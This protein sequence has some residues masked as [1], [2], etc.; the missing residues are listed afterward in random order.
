MT[1]LVTGG[2]GQLG[3]ALRQVLPSATFAGSELDITDRTALAAHDW[4]GTTAIVNAAAWTA[5]DAAEQQ[6]RL[7]E[8][9]A[10]TLDAVRE[11]TDASAR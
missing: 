9:V 11:R 1:V 5:V 3:R 8:A 2:S 4:S 7:T 10:M 6:D